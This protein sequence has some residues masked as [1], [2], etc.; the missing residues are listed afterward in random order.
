MAGVRDARAKLP[1]D[2]LTAY[3]PAIVAFFR[4]RLRDRTEAE[5]AAQD[6][7]VR[8]TQRGE[9]D[10][11]DNVEAY[12]FEA[13]ANHL[14]D[15]ARRAKARPRLE[16]EG[17]AD[18]GGRLRTEITPERDLIGRDM[19]TAVKRALLE[20]PER[21]R[22]I[23]MLS[24]YEQMTAREIAAAFGISQRMV[25]KHISRVLAH[26]RDRLS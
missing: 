24:R 23:F 1:I 17:N 22:T 21:Q 12:V 5:D 9:L 16:F 4:R 7:L 6:V 14:R 3:R 8:L 15:R 18:P 2:W 10:R 11:H 26:L 13:A 19:L 25:E 20:L